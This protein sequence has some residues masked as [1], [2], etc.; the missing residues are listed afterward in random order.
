MADKSICSNCG[1]TLKDQWLVCKYCNQARWKMIAPYFAWG[2]VFLVGAWWTMTH[3]MPASA[4]PENLFITMIQVL[5]TIFGIIGVVMLSMALVA[6]LRGLSVRKV[7]T[8][9]QAGSRPVWPAPPP[10][11]PAGKAAINLTT[12]PPAPVIP[13]AA[14]PVY[15]NISQIVPELHAAHQEISRLPNMSS[16]LGSINLLPI[17]IEKIV[18]YL[19]NTN[20]MD[21]ETAFGYFFKFGS[22]EL[23]RWIVK[24]LG[25][26]EEKESLLAL[27]VISE[28]D[29]YKDDRE[30]PDPANAGLD[31]YDRNLETIYP[32]REAALAEIKKKGSLIKETNPVNAESQGLQ[33]IQ[34]R[35]PA[36]AASAQQK[37]QTIHCQKCQHENAPDAMKCSQ[38]GTNLLPGAGI[39]QRL[40]VFGC[41]TILA[42]VS[43]AIAYGVYASKAEIGGKGVIYLGGLVLFGVFVFGF[44]I[45]WSLRRTPLYERYAARANRHVS[46]NPVQA[47]A[48]YG[49]ALN[50]APQAQAFDILLARARL[51]QGQGMVRE[52]GT[53]W[54][55]A[56]E[57]I[58][59]RMAKPK[60]PIELNK[61]RA[62]LYKTMGME[63]EYALEMLRYTIEKE[64]T[65]K[66]KKDGIAM[67][68]EE[69]FK[70][71]TEEVARKE[72]QKL[73]A[74]IMSNHRY[75]I[76]GQC[77]NC[78]CEVDLDGRLDCTNNAKHRKI[79]NIRPALRIT[80]PT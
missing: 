43:L 16:L 41:T 75:R 71:G 40:G 44:G 1:N 55:R 20:E 78:R 54:Q 9:F 52:A 34:A 18:R 37:S 5:A 32:I 7:T 64:K 60:A 30:I 73:R 38:C 23:R 36:Q 56:L 6:A 66:F 3:W 62:E 48:D 39:G 29:P 12:S 13:K 57:N 27:A 74:E 46:L 58:N 70:K 31:Y 72:L 47:I 28:R 67:G 79:S 33:S 63:D 11:S 51:Y 68:V 14:P 76:V 53:D 4:K 10:G 69:G 25:A 50:G 24:I 45:I 80:A 59:A 17:N 22:V 2:A 8:P 61:Q 49:S 42:I 65:F 19:M 26:T 21:R 77:N 35:Q 15:F